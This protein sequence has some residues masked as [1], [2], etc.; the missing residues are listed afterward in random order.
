MKN[1]LYSTKQNYSQKIAGFSYSL[2]YFIYCNVVLVEVR[3]ENMASHREV[4]KE[5][6]NSLLANYACFLMSH[7]I[8]H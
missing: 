3:G 2:L 4:R 6:F 1:K 7:K 8:G 5:Y